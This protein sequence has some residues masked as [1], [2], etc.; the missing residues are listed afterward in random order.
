M[1]SIWKHPQSRFYYAHFSL[2]GG[3]RTN[4]ST[5]EVDA[6]KAQKIA[7]AY[8]LA[9]RER[10]TEGQIRRVMSDLFERVS[11]TPLPSSTARE[12]LTTWIERKRV[13][14]GPRTAERY[15]RTVRQFLEFLGDRA[16][17]E[18]MFISSKDVSHFRDAL[19]KRLTASSANMA[20][21]ILRI[22]FQQAFRDGLINENPAAKVTVIKRR[23][24]TQARRAFTLPE[25]GRLLQQAEG[26]WR[27]LILFGFYTGQ[28]LGD[29]ARLTWSN[30]HRLDSGSPELRFV[31][32]KTG[33]QQL[34]PI[35]LPLLRF[36]L[37]ELPAAD[38]PHA[39][40]FPRASE[41]VRSQ[42]DRT[43][44]L[45]GQFYRLMASAGL[46]PPRSHAAKQDGQGRS[47]KRVQ[48]ELSFHCLR[49]TATSL[50]KNA[51]ISAAVVQDIIGHDSPAVSAHY[52]HID[53]AAKRLAMGAMPDVTS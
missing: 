51:G 12:H 6:K 44:T 21:K 29:L 49:H 30:L 36:I 18:L 14:N 47:A 53:M 31:S 16:D 41:I 34:N 10:M 27:G 24:E 7:D 38:D 37:D 35:S 4:R 32:G 23:G 33:R 3:G 9:A 11:G 50:M 52:T 8:E 26:E 45:S 28:R 40:L 17:N 13:E 22:A 15:G 48:N 43:G 46:V 25:L 19:A 20:L 42:Q 2:P 1:A 5:K 39:P